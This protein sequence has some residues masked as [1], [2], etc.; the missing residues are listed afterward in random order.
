LDLIDPLVWRK[1]ADDV[2][3]DSRMLPDLGS[4]R[5]LEMF[6]RILVC[7][8]ILIACIPFLC[9]WGLLFQEKHRFSYKLDIGNGHTLKVWSGYGSDP[10]GPATQ[11]IY[12]QIDRGWTEVVHTTFVEH[13]DGGL[14]EFRTVFA[15]QGALVCVYEINRAVKNS[16]LVFIFD[17]NCRKSWPRDR[18]GEPGMRSP[19]DIVWRMQ[20]QKLKAENPDLPTPDCF[21]Q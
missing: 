4:K 8:S 15:E 9:C 16:F 21:R 1:L 19:E 12:Y 2:Q 7:I 20:F 3:R 13:D 14:Y 17:F 6:Q 18:G 11:M 10:F 5:D